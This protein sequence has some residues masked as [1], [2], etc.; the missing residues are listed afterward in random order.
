[1]SVLRRASTWPPGGSY[2]ESPVTDSGQN[3]SLSLV[4][5]LASVSAPITT[6]QERFPNSFGSSSICSFR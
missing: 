4:L 6:V 1:M 3:R 5:A 2:S